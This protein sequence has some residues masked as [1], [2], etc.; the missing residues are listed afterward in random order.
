MPEMELKMIRINQLKLNYNHSERDLIFK[1]ADKLRIKKDRIAEE[2]LEY[3]I[4]K[5]SIDARFKPDFKFVYSVDVTLKNEKLINKKVFDE[6]IFLTEE[7]KYEFTPSGTIS[8][9]NR[10]VIAGLGPAG[11]FCG[12]FLAK[13]G[14]APIIIERGKC[15]EERKRDVNAFF[16]GEALNTESNVQFGEGGAGT[17]SDG[18]LNTLVKDKFLRNRLVLE[19]LVEFGAKP[20]ILYENKPHIG[21]DKLS[22]IVVN[23]RKAITKMGGEVLFNTKL[24]NIFIDEGKLVGIEVNGEKRIDTE[25]LV[26]AVGHSARDTFEML[27]NKGIEMEAKSFAVG[28]RIEHPQLIIDE[29]MYGKDHNAFENIEAAEY[30]VTY[31]SSNERG[32]YSFC[33]CPGGYV[34]NAS[35]ENG[36]IA[37]N[38]M[39]YSGRDGVNANSAIIV[40]VNPMDYGSEA[41]LAAIGFQR[42]LEENAYNEGNGNIPIQLYG[43][44]CSNICSQSLGQVTPQIKGKY[45]FGNIRNILPQEICNSLIEGIEYFGKKIDGFNR[46]DAV[47]SAVESRTSSPVRIRRND[48]FISNVKGIYPC[49]EG[50]GYAGGITSAA[51][52]GVRVFEAIAKIYKSVV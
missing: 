51:M 6:N 40:S 24:T 49:G 3:N 26:V 31:T 20:S 27:Y 4:V 19:T 33:M 5:K 34:V 38:G 14:Y 15:V 48:D 21:T 25:N 18:K 52:D 45:S 50:A 11:L 10:P 16:E 41:P 7:K 13:H 35:S 47:L 43:D 17:F 12:Y 39:S 22:E 44:F 30:K 36:R 42:K 1:I 8:M 32:V 2:I 28:V 37:I 29:N 46:A 23:I 9:K